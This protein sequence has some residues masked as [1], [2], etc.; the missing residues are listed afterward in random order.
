[1][2]SSPWATL[3]SPITPQTSAIPNAASAKMAPISAPS[4]SSWTARTGASNNNRRLSI[5]G[6]G[7]SLRHLARPDQL[8]LGP[9]GGRD[10]L[11]GPVQHLV[12][13]HLLGDVL[14]RRVELDGGEH[15]HE[16][17]AGDGVAHLLRIER[18][19]ALEGV[20]EDEHH[21]RRLGGLV[22]RGIRELLLEALGI[23]IGGA[24]PLVAVAQV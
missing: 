14:P 6:V 17:G 11:V 23:L 3:M 12:E 21:G 1:M 9:L 24:E 8:G 16:I 18:P 20:G 13:H 10:D 2:T 15:R 22:G 7:T 19:R 4:S 5:S